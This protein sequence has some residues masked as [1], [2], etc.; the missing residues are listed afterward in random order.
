MVRLEPTAVLEREHPDWIFALSARSTIRANTYAQNQPQSRFFHSERSG[1]SRGSSISRGTPGTPS[2]SIP[3]NVE[4]PADDRVIE[5]WL[6]VSNILG[7]SAWDSRFGENYWYPVP[8]QVPTIPRQSVNYRWSAISNL[9]MVCLV[10]DAAQ[11]T[12]HI[13]GTPQFPVGSMHLL[14]SDAGGGDRFGFDDVVYHGS[15]MGA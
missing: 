4:V 5:L 3:V 1:L 13:F 8:S 10:S 7:C 14:G 11:K 9:E 15:G 2:I 12:K 6:Q